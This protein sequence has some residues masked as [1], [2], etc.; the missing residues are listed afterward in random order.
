MSAEKDMQCSKNTSYIKLL[1]KNFKIMVK[2]FVVQS[3]SDV[4]AKDCS[5]SYAIAK[6]T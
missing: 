5:Y 3:M 6:F 2:L 4:I 1:L